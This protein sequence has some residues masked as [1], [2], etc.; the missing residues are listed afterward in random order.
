VL[1]GRR[2]LAGVTIRD[3]DGRIVE[4]RQFHGSVTDVADGVVVLR[5]DD[6][7]EALLPAD[8]NAYEPARPGTY[9]LPSGVVVVDPDYLTTWEIVAEE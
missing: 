5:Q 6:G 8:P 2:L 7:T 9:R 3:T 4:R 1:V